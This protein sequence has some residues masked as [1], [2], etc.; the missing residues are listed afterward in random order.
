MKLS[1]EANELDMYATNDE[2]IYPQSRL[3]AKNLI[4]FMIKGEYDS[5]LAA[6][7]F[8]YPIDRASHNYRKEIGNSGGTGQHAF[9]A[10]VRREVADHWAFIFEEAVLT[11]GGAYEYAHAYHITLPA[12]VLKLARSRRSKT[13]RVAGRA[14]P[15]GSLVRIPLTKGGYDPRGRYYGVGAPLYRYEGTDGEEMEFRAA[16]RATAIGKVKN[17]F[18]HARF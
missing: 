4:V 3:I 18:P 13:G 5:R 6:R 17:K 10:P 2:R 9:S 16:N 11:A 8:I 1:P 14:S 12:S 15:R 7:A